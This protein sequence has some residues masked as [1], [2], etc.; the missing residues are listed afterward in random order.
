[1]CVCASSS[2]GISFGE[3]THEKIELPAKLLNY[4]FMEQ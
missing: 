1:V 3:Y 2:M 4:F